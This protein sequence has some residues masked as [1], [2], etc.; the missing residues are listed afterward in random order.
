MPINKAKTEALAS[1][2]AHWLRTLDKFRT[3]NWASIKSE[4]EF[5]GILSL[6]PTPALQNQY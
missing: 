5:S 4:L 3:A 6:F 1:V 2:R